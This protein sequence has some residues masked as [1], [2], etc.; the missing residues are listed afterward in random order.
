MVGA[1]LVGH[2]GVKVSAGFV[3]SHFGCVLVAALWGNC[4]EGRGVVRCL[5]KVILTG[6]E[7]EHGGGSV[8]LPG[9]SR[10]GGLGVLAVISVC[11]LF[12]M[13]RLNVS[14]S[15]GQSLALH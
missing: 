6:D 15:L 8:V 11:G 13:A 14:G 2:V 9:F 12:F 5:L 4:A 10:R 7:L 3:G 1:S